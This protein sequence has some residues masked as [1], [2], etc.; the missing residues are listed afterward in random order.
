M[1]S[2]VVAAVGA[3]PSST[4]RSVPSSTIRSVSSST[5][6]T[7]SAI[8]TPA[9]T[10]GASAAI[11]IKWVSP[12]VERPR[13]ECAAVKLEATLVVRVRL[14]DLDGWAAMA[15]FSRRHSFKA[16]RVTA[17]VGGGT[18]AAFRARRVFVLLLLLARGSFTA[19]AAALLVV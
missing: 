15:L 1:H 19:P 18:A 16:V 17:A 13:T 2:A 11:P 10:A 6:G 4:I 7:I 12:L 14:D 8:R 3:V 9:I 5:V